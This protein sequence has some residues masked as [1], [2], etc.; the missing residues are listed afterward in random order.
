MGAA[1]GRTEVT[2]KARRRLSALLPHGAGY[3]LCSLK[4]ETLV[5]LSVLLHLHEDKRDNAQGH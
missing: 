1:P 4:R 2:L 5:H 3:L